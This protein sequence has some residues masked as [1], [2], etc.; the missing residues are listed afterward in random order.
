MVPAVVHCVFSVGKIIP[1][2]I[3]KEFVLGCRRPVVM[4]RG[5]FLVKSLYFLQ[6][7]HVGADTAQPVA[8]VVDGHAPLELR[9][10]FVDVVSND[11]EFFHFLGL[12][13]PRE[14]PLREDS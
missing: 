12:L 10:P 13:C 8:Q 5:M 4:A 6:E 2:G 9:E 7:H 11:L 3:C 14:T 1:D